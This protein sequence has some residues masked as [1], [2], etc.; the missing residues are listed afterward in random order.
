MKKIIIICGLLFFVS[1]FF[2]MALA[3]TKRDIAIDRAIGGMEEG[4]RILPPENYE[5]G[6]IPEVSGK[7]LSPGMDAKVIVSSPSPEKNVIEQG[8]PGGI[9]V[10]GVE[11]V[12]G[13]PDTG[14]GSTGTGESGTGNTGTE[15]PDTGGAIDIGAGS[16]DVGGSGSEPGTGGAGTRETSGGTSNPIIDIDASADLSSGTVE[17]GVGVDTSGG[18]LLDADAGA[19]DAGSAG[20][21]EADI[22][23]ASDLTGQSPTITEPSS[24]ISPPSDLSAEIDT[25]GQ[26]VGGTTDVGV[27]ADVSG[28]GEADDVVSDPADGTSLGL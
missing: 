2:S 24:V 13:P 14:V 15:N 6:T 3:D 8:A 19:T 25:T 27:E 21:L 4:S 23:S 10:G 9:F 26:T 28:T 17:A 7:A 5:K 18:Q 12:S 16:G 20:T 22:G 1:G 11:H